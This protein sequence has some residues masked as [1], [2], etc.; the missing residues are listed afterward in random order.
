VLIGVGVAMAPQSLVAPIRAHQSFLV[1]LNRQT[2]ATRWASWWIGRPQ[3]VG[4]PLDMPV[5]LFIFSR[6]RPWPIYAG[7]V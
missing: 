7:Q 1:A 3:R 6:D 2:P 4:H 5:A